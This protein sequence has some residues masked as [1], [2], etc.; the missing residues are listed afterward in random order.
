MRTWPG[1][2]CCGRR[3]IREELAF[4]NEHALRGEAEALEVTLT[5]YAWKRSEIERQLEAAPAA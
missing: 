1:V 2:A 5:H 4:A 3:Q